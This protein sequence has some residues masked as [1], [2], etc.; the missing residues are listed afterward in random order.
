MN[1]YIIIIVILLIIYLLTTKE[2]ERFNDTVAYNSLFVK[3]KGLFLTEDNINFFIENYKN[4]IQQIKLTDNIQYEKSNYSINESEIDNIK[5][6][7]EKQF[8]FVFNDSV[9]IIKSDLKKVNKIPDIFSGYIYVEVGDFSYIVLNEI[10]IIKKGLDYG[11]VELKYDGILSKD[12]VVFYQKL[13][14][15]LQLNKI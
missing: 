8:N 6:F 4:K 10:K 1:L 3:P 11:I 5:N 15:P 2:I 9:N 12:D 13:T 7:L 14:H